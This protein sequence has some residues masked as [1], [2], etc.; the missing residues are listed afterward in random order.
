MCQDCR[1]ARS[2]GTIALDDGGGPVPGPSGAPEVWP[3]LHE[4]EKRR[5][6]AA[7]GRAERLK[8]EKVQAHREARYWKAQWGRARNALEAARAEAEDLRRVS[9][10]ALHLRSE[11]DR[12]ETLLAAI[13]VDTR[14]RSTM[15]SLRIEN[16]RLQAG[17]EAL[18]KQLHEVESERDGLRSQ[19]ETLSRAQFGRK[20][21]R[22]HKG[23]GHKGTGRKTGP[24]D[25][26]KAG[27][28]GPRP[29]GETHGRTPRPE[30]AREREVHDPPPEALHCPCCNAPRVANGSHTSDLIEVE[31]KA[32]VRVI[33][34]S[35][36][37]K[38]CQCSDT[39]EEVSAPPVPRLFPRTMFG[40]SVWARLLFEL[41]AANRPLRR[42]A[43]W[44]E[45][46][47][48]PVSP[49]T[50]SDGHDRMVAL[51][52][53]LSAAILA[54][55]QQAPVVHADE[56]SWRV[57]EFATTGSSS[58]AWLWI[59]TCVDAVY[60][61][62]DASRSA[63]AAATLLGGLRKGTVL[64]CDRYSAYKK[65]ARL[66]AGRLVLAFCW[67]HVRRDFIKVAAARGDLEDW[68]DQWLARIRRL[69]RLNAQRLRYHDPG[70]SPDRR[71]Y[72]RMQFRLSR[73]L[74][75]V[76]T[77]A[78]RELAT[79]DDASPQAKVLRSLLNH[80]EGLSQVLDDLRVPMDNNLAER[81]FRPEVIRRKLSLG[82]DSKEGA[83]G[84]AKILSVV[85][86]LEVNDI[87]VLPW[88]E[89]WLSACA[90]NGGRPPEDLG[91]WLP[92]TMDEARR[93]EFRA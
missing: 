21:E 65:L 26:G 92:W 35:R 88:L 40:I 87:A 4:E 39:P 78:E 12:L 37:R 20:S 54:H 70:R 30:L 93:A 10:D 75:E 85:R 33:D 82:S 66:A 36:W 9:K 84:M 49:G 11:V 59:A 16:G 24:D 5:A 46:Q 19:V 23:T 83:Q 6:D 81:R 29:G 14:K 50:L 69:Y 73:V 80:R 61:H 91:P 79:V 2:S 72:L 7:D 76:F 77:E 89:A 63:A 27:K 57:R 51:F 43:A 90:D 71:R 47:G 38:T 58:R 48:L 22:G 62:V 8:R 74:G 34:R 52:A 86:T 56:T 3:R 42:V 31:V 13:G 53:P 55:L 1:H 28:R 15:A 41:Y 18:G 60:L 25:K 17:S 67:A 64:V 68:K 45:A 44:F 32:H